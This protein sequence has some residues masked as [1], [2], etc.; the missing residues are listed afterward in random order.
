MLSNVLLAKAMLL[1]TPLVATVGLSLG[2]PLAMLSDVVRQK[3]GGFTAALFLGTAAVWL[4]FIGV[5]TADMLQRQL[6]RVREARLVGKA[7]KRRPR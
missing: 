7:A 3:S 6:E 4:G 2:I 1:A 5:S